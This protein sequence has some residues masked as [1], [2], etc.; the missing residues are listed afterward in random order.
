MLDPFKRAD[1]IQHF[2]KEE[3]SHVGWCWMKFVSEQIFHP[4]FSCIQH[5]KYM[6][7][8]FKVVAS[9]T[10]NTCCIRLKWFT[11][12]HL[13]SN[14]ISDIDFNVFECSNVYSNVFIKNNKEVIVFIQFSV[15]QYEH[16]EQ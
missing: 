15:L 13:I 3:K 8:S 11:I 2:I 12:Q 9:N 7:Y 5:Q 10:K 16:H 4:L 6:L 1:F 14:T